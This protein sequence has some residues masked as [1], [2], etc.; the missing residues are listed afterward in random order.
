MFGKIKQIF[1]MHDF[2]NLGD[3]KLID[4]LEIETTDK[5]LKCGKEIKHWYSCTGDIDKCSNKVG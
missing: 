4:T 5:C 2:E 3:K 1:C